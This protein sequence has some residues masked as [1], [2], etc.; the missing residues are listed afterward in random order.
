MWTEFGHSLGIVMS[1]GVRALKY[2]KVGRS[3]KNIL[4][5][6]LVTV[7]AGLLF[8]KHISKYKSFFLDSCHQNVLY[9]LRTL[10]FVSTLPPARP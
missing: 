3:Q 8:N 10:N 1:P 2:T 9:Y 7:Q 6:L 5:H 4:G